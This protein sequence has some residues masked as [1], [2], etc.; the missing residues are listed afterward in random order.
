ML[1]VLSEIRKQVGKEF[2]VGIKLNS[3]D[4]QHGGFD[5]EE[6]IEAILAL[7]SEGIDLVEISGGTY[8][9]PAMVGSRRIKESTQ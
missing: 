7:E 6:S 5:E 2:P 9:A 3:A 8:E 1:A 4:F